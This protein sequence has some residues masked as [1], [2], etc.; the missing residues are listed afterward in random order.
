MNLVGRFAGSG[1]VE[2]AFEA[3]G[4]WL[5]GRCSAVSGQR[6]DH[7]AVLNRLVPI[8][9]DLFAAEISAYE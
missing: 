5:D 4:Y 3:E 2:I 9:T 1:R 7:G 6:L 8:G